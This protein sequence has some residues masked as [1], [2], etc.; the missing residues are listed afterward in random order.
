MFMRDR[1]QFSA[2]HS[3]VWN[4]DTGSSNRVLRPTPIL[5][6]RLEVVSARPQ[7]VQL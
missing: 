5:S 6:A 7:N 3:A 1:T 2:E 4:R